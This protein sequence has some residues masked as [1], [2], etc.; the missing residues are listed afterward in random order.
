[1]WNEQ[2]GLGAMIL[3]NCGQE[4]QIFTSAETMNIT[5]RYNAA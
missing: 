3:E 1:M 2:K 4:A 5:S